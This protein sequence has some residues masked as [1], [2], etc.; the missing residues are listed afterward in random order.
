MV[1][2]FYFDDKG[3]KIE[4]EADIN[5]LK[6]QIKQELIDEFE[7]EKTNAINE[8]IKDIDNESICDIIDG[9]NLDLIKILS[10]YPSLKVEEIIEIIKNANFSSYDKQKINKALK[11]EYKTI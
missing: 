11:N 5:E 1:K 10:Y 7:K 6:E 9:N 8:I 3:N 4:F 2:L